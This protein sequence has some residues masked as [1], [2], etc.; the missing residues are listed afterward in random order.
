MRIAI[1]GAGKLGLKVINALV[2]GDH[3]ITVFDTNEAVLNKIS[4]ETTLPKTTYIREPA[5]GMTQSEVRNS[6]WGSPQDI[7]RTTTVYGVREQWCYSGY[8]YIYFDDGIV[9]S[10][11]D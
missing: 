6:T 7:N 9:T 2:G 5:I 10:I 4:N 8:R 3:A 1:V 11:Q